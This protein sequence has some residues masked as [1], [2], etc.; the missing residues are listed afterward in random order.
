[1]MDENYGKIALLRDVINS[2]AMEVK[3]KDLYYLL[4]VICGKYLTLK[5]GDC[6]SYSSCYLTFVMNCH[7][8]C[9]NNVIKSILDLHIAKY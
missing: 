9:A 7:L 8:T 6:L 1:M 5:A 2:S 4:T 3:S